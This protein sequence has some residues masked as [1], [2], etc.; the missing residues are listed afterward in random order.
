[1]LIITPV[2][3]ATNGQELRVHIAGE[4]PPKPPR[5][6]DFDQRKGI[7]NPA[8]NPNAGGS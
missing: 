5:K 1:M 6:K 3:Y 7:R 8:L 4:A 2:D